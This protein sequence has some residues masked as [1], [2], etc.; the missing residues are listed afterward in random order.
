MIIRTAQDPQATVDWWR[1]ADAP[2]SFVA[3]CIELAAAWQSGPSYI[4]HLPVCFDGSCSGIQHLAMMMR[5]ENIGRLVNL[6]PDDEPH[7]VYQL[8][9]DR[10]IGYL[11]KTD[12]IKAGWWLRKVVTRKLVK[13]PAMTFAYSAS[14]SG[15]QD[16]I[17][18]IENG[19]D[20]F[21]LAQ[22]VMR[23][24]KGTLRQPAKAMGF[25]RKLAKECTDKSKV[26]EWTSPTGFP[27]ANRYHKSKIKTVHLEL[28]GEHVRHRV[29]DGYEPSLL[30][31]KSMN[32]AAPNFVHALDASHL[33]R[34]INTAASEG[35]TSIAVV[36][37]SFGCLAPRAYKL[38]LVI[39]E[40]MARLYVEHDVLAE[41]RAAAGS[42]EPLPAGGT[43]NPWDV[44]LSSYAFA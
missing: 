3:G 4:T 37:D 36:H 16:H 18:E 28:R 34:V 41:L 13:R 21:F 31:G 15:M 6:A 8:I 25:I 19:G 17:E 9:T 32:S 35:I 10:V 12:D 26:L 29:A 27:W 7:D 30:K 40:E 2:F 22:Y 20:A 43:L 1:D 33:I 5:D 24:C 44:Q 23:A 38:H 14:V 42:S 11:Q 39:R